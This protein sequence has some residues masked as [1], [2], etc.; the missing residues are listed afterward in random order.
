MLKNPKNQ[1]FEADFLQK[2][3]QMFL[4]M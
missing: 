2:W 3:F 1:I 4:I